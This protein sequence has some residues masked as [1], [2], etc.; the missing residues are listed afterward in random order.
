MQYIN[1]PNIDQNLENHE[2]STQKNS[3][4]ISSIG[5]KFKISQ[6]EVI[7]NQPNPKWMEK[8]Y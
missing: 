2:I 3:I 7:Q 5:K 4:R 8:V 1:E 6:S